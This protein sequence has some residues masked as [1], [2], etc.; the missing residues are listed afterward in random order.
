VHA[1]RAR[2]DEH[3][4]NHPNVSVTYVYDQPLPDDEPHATGLVTPELLARALP[5]DR[6]V[7]LYFLGPKPFM[8]AVY[9]NGLALGVAANRLRY[10]FFGPLEDLQA[11]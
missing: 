4:A 7:D 10:E 8:Q 11:A 3:A 2:V 6:D 9:R 5:A 1:F